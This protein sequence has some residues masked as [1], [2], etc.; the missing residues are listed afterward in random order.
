MREGEK[1]RYNDRKRGS[2]SENE[3]K[4]QEFACQKLALKETKKEKN[5]STVQQ[6]RKKKKKEQKED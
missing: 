3:R 4:S 1:E 6:G 2:E 5:S